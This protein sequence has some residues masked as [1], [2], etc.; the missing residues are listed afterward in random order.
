MGSVVGEAVLVG[1]VNNRNGL[2][3]G[4]GHRHR[5]GAALGGSGACPPVS[6]AHLL[7]NNQT[8]EAIDAIPQKDNI[9][10][11]L[12]NLFGNSLSKSPFTNSLDFISSGLSLQNC[13]RRAG[14]V[15]P[16]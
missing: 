6:T 8:D 15:A 10:A 13:A 5:G 4:I 11:V 2:I 14:M 16:K 9:H 7:N 1:L 12:L 3:E